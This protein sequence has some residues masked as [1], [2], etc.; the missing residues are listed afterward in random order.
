M[1]NVYFIIN[2][3]PI[4]MFVVDT[5]NDIVKIDSIKIFL[6]LL[7][8][9]YASYTLYPV[10]KVLEKMFNE[11][12]WFKYAILFILTV[13]ALHPLDNKKFGISLIMPGVILFLFSSLRAQ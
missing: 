9:V 7:A 8:G 1:Y 5:I 10:P 4:R 2:P 12:M 3:L 6:L 13:I 11:S